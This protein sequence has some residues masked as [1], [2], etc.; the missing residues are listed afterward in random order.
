MLLEVQ[1]RKNFKMLTSECIYSVVHLSAASAR[2]PLKF[3]FQ[4]LLWPCQKAP[5]M[6]CTPIEPFHTRRLNCCELQRC[7]RA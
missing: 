1:D 6:H 2:E 7:C 3:Q 5:L 4:V